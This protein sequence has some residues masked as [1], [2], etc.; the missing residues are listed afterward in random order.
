MRLGIIGAGRI[1]EALIS[2]LLKAGFVKPSGVMASDVSEA[3]LRHISS[4]YGVECV[5]DNVKV[6]RSCETVVL[7]VKP[8]DVHKVLEEI[9]GEL[10]ASHLLISIAAGVA[11][12]YIAKVLSKRVPI[13]RAMPNVAVLVREGMTVVAPGPWA[14]EHHVKLAEELFSSVGKVMRLPEDFF[15]AV[16]ALSG[17]GPAYASLIV[18]AMIDAGIRVGLPREAA[19]ILAAQSVLGAAKMLLETGEHPAKLREMVTTPAGVT[20]EG[21][22]E[23]EE[24]RLRA[25]IIKAITRATQRSKELLN[26]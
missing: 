5:S 10:T 3:R 18:E 26:Q 1:G 4:A 8:K 12:S 20:I 14:E 16:T 19:T 2:G 7:S 23:L 11:T 21:I 25:T 24:G 17:S 13:V 9:K 6:A 15:D 22:V